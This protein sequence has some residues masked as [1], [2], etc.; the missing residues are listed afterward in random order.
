MAEFK[1]KKHHFVH[2]N[3]QPTE[4]VKEETYLARLK[5]E[6]EEAEGKTLSDLQSHHNIRTYISIDAEI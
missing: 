3:V 4:P 1:N 5:R 6:A 2:K